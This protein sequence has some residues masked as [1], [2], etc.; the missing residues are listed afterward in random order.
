[1]Q[2]NIAAP[3]A[4]N[5]G[6]KVLMDFRFYY[7]RSFFFAHFPDTLYEF[8]KTIAFSY[9]KLSIINFIYSYID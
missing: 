9:G 1:M 6:R 2:F 7:F 8:G 5:K 4:P 3:D